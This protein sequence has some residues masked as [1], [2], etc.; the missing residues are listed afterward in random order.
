MTTPIVD[1]IRR[2]RLSRFF[3]EVIHGGKP[4][5]ASTN[6][7]LFIEAICLQPDPATCVSKILSSTSGLSTL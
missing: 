1:D 7:R 6:G 4:V 5:T 2:A 3:N